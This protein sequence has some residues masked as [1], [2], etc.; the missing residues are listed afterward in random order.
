MKKV[1]VLRPRWFGQCLECGNI[2]E[3]DIGDNLIAPTYACDTESC[4]GDVLD[5]W[6]WD[7]PI[8]MRLL[9]EV[10]NNAKF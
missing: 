2:Y 5:I 1:R 6:A 3:F 7:T 8:G 4:N 10:Y 9:K